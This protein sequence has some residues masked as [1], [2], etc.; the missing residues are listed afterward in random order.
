[1][2]NSL[3]KERPALFK[4]NLIKTPTEDDAKDPHPFQQ[5]SQDKFME[6]TKV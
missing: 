1:M 3:E 5:A 6:V 2:I 4:A